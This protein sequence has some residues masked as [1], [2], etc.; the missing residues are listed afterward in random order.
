VI[1]GIFA[2]LSGWFFFRMP[3]DACHQ[4]SGRQVVVVT[5]P[6]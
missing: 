5:P 4:I 3:V 1:V 6:R 2:A